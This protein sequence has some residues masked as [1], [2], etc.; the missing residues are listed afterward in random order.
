MIEG[1]D[2]S[3]LYLHLTIVT[4]WLYNFF[5]QIPPIW[6]FFFRLLWKTATGSGTFPPHFP[7]YARVCSAAAEQTK[8]HGAQ[9]DALE[10][11]T[12]RAR[13]VS[14][15]VVFV[16]YFQRE[17]TDFWNI[18]RWR[19]ILRFLFFL[20]ACVNWLEWSGKENSLGVSS[21]YQRTGGRLVSFKNKLWSEEECLLDRKVD[22]WIAFGECAL[23]KS[24]HIA[25]MLL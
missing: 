8:N 3:D 25:Y 12:E 23:R 2:T 11:I 21:G 9:Q 15:S 14:V 20:Q 22:W 17:W 18:S 7:T 5:Y 16:S 13:K 6:F 10:R 19:V 24:P 1:T 4:I